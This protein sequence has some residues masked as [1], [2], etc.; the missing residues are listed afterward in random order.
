MEDVLPDIFNLIVNIKSYKAISISCDKWK[1]IN[2]K[3]IAKLCNRVS[4]INMFPDKKWDW[5]ILLH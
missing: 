1:K 5:S 4:L 2:I 3:S